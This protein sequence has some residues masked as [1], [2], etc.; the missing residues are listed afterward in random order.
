MY[1]N[2]G[3]GGTLKSIKASSILWKEIK[4]KKKRQKKK[5]SN[6]LEYIYNIFLE[7]RIMIEHKYLLAGLPGGF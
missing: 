3:I 6:I 7:Y 2:P 5:K 1:G 4:K